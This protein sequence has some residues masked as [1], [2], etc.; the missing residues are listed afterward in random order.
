MDSNPTGVMRNEDSGI[1]SEQGG[2][3]FRAVR[4]QVHG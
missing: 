3:G 2:N 4:I 1:E